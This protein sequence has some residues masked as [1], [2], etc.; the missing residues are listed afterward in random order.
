MA[1]GSPLLSKLVGMGIPV[2]LL[3]LKGD[4][5]A[6]GFRATCLKLDNLQS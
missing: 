2:N 3:G 5:I 1:L 6:N 4:R